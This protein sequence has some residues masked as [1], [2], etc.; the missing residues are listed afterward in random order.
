MNYYDGRGWKWGDQEI[1]DVEA[2]A[3]QWTAETKGPRFPVEFLEWFRKVY[4]TA[5]DDGASWS[6]I[7]MLHNVEKAKAS[8]EGYDIRFWMRTKAGAYTVMNFVKSHELD[9]GLRIDYRYMT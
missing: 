7:E 1:E 3:S 6:P 9:K 8:V 5:V 4:D 2:V